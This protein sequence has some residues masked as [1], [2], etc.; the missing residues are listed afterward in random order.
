MFFQVKAESSVARKA[1][2]Q[3]GDIN[4]FNKYKSSH[5]TVAN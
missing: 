2:L 3:M 5:Y 4:I 1:V